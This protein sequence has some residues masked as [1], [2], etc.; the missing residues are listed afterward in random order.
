MESYDVEPLAGFDPQIGILLASLEDSTRE[1]MGE[2]GD[3]PVEAIVWQPFPDSYSIGTILLHIIDVEDYWFRNFA[4]G[5]ERDPAEVK[6]WLSE[7]TDVD[8]GIWPTPPAKPL[9]WYL[10]TLARVRKRA[11]EALK[12]IEPERI[13]ERR[14]RMSLTLRWIVAHVVEHDSYHGGQAVLL[15]ELWKKNSGTL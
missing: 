8:G 12:G 15:N 7:E 13:Y 4:A 6:E 2:L 5:L 14:G 11:F 3:C 1:W 9:S 10:E